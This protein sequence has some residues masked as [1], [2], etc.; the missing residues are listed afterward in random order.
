LET[1]SI[2]CGLYCGRIAGMRELMRAF[3]DVRFVVLYVREA[4]PGSRIPAHATMAEKLA[5]ARALPALE[6]EPRTILVDDLEGT[7]HL[8]L[9]GFPNLLTVVDAHGIIVHRGDWNHVDATRRVLQRFTDGV[10]DA[11]VESPFSRVPWRV[12]ARVFRRAG[13]DALWD[14]LRQLPFLIWAQWRRERSKR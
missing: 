4:H 10:L 13:F 5:R 7:G 14:F 9:G 8:A 12:E 2:T 6:A 3:P 11:P 1:G